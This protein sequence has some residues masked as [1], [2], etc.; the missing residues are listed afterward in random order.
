MVTKK[1]FIILAGLSLSVSTQKPWPYPSETGNN[2][3]ASIQN[4]GEACV[5]AGGTTVAFTGVLVGIMLLKD[6]PVIGTTSLVGGIALE[7]LLC[8]GGLLYACT[9]GSS[10]DTPEERA[11]LVEA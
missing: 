8:A 9:K 11:R 2:S 1:I 5:F 6:H 3:N 10:S 7:T 4:P